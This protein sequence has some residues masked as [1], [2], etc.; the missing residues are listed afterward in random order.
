[1]VSLARQLSRYQLAGF[2]QRTLTGLTDRWTGL[3]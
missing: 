1:M 3:P 2:G